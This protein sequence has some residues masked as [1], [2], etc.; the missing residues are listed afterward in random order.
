MLLAGE[1]TELWTEEETAGSEKK[2][3]ESEGKPAGLVP[4]AG[5]ETEGCAGL[6]G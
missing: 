3:Q 2:P 5:P 4:G 1:G 6:Q